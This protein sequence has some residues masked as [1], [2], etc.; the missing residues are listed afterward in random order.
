MSSRQC[1]RFHRDT[2]LA[3]ELNGAT[4]IIRSLVPVTLVIPWEHGI[5]PSQGIEQSRL[6]GP[7][8]LC[9][10]KALLA[11]LDDRDAAIFRSCG[12]PGAGGFLAQQS[13]PDVIMDNASFRIAVARRLGG[14]LRPAGGI[15][16][17]C[18]H[19]GQ[20][21]SCQSDID[22]TG[23]HSDIC[24]DG[25]FVIQRHDRVLRWLHKRSSQGQTSSPPQIE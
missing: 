21:G 12:S 9:A 5:P 2:R 20:R 3:A 23:S 4:A 22:P 10:H 7:Y 15:S 24:T 25:G 14:G 19:T 13:D 16:M 1:K 11:S 8:C 18:C 6:I 17:R